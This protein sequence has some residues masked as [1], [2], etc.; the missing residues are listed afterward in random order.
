MEWKY[1]LHAHFEDAT[2]LLSCSHIL[3]DSVRAAAAATTTIH[4]HTHTTMTVS[5]MAT[6]CAQIDARLSLTL[7]FCLSAFC[8]W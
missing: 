8:F 4:T 5:T 1:E 3:Y 6:I 7:L 2:N